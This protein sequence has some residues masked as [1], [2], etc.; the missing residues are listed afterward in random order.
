MCIGFC[1]NL[2]WQSQSLVFKRFV[3][4]NPWLELKCPWATNL[5]LLREL[6]KI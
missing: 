4:F 6:F 2:N 5:G 1:Q 3:C